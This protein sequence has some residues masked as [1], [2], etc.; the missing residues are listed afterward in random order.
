MITA[1]TAVLFTEEIYR[2][3]NNTV[4]V[5]SQPWE[6]IGEGARALLQKILQAV[7]LSTDSVTIIHQSTLDI[8]TMPSRPSRVI[9]FGSAPGITPFEPFKLDAVQ[10]INAPPLEM[11]L[12][13]AAAKQKLWAGLKVL[14]NK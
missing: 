9:F 3:D 12:S 4:V 11:L 5:S 13:D 6:H 1:V 7:G 8:N 2:I 10:A 14:F